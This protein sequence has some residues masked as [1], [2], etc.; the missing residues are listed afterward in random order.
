MPAVG[1]FELIVLF[2]LGILVVC[3]YGA[4]AIAKAKGYSFWLFAV[5][6]VIFAP[7]PLLVA[8][9]LPQAR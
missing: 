8:A 6:G 1:P 3:G 9:V 2:A 5:L 7:I 4:G